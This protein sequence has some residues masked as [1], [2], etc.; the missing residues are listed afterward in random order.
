MA[1]INE[2]Q[3]TT[4]RG[5][6]ALA[7]LG[8]AAPRLAR[9]QPGFPDRPM[10]FIV[11][12]PPGSSLDA[13][14]R[15]MFDVVRRDLGQQVILENRPGARGTLGAQA[16]LQARP[17]GYTLAQQHLSIL[18]QP[19]LTR[20]PTWDPVGDFSYIMQFSGFTFGVVVRSDSPYRT[21]ADLIAAAR[22]KPGTVTYST[23]GVSTSNHIAM[24]DILAR[25]KVEMTHVPFRGAQEGV[26][27]LL[28]RQI[29]CVADAQAWRPNVETGEF[30]LL[31]VWT[32]ERLSTFPDAPT[33][34]ELG[35]DMVVTSPYGVA[36]PKGMDP[37]V[38]HKLHGSFRKAL[39]DETS[40]AVMRRWEMP[41]EYLG[42]ED[43]LAFVR[44]RI[45]YEREMVTRLR[46]SID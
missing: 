22:A 29:D 17:D 35:Y 40:Q 24:E 3:G 23:S 43:Y 14:L 5:A 34:R 7:A 30:R 19:F 26:T 11:P 10:R 32:R 21:W 39:F 6:L 8:L 1:A 9:A 15:S 27:A 45:V 18:R 36:G 44:E 20:Q 25:E 37:A 38:V 16:L 41:L 2:S 33:L 28:G 31:C 4:R 46:L 42:P 12:W 13:L